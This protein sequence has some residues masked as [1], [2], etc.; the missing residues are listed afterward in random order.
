MFR[1]TPSDSISLPLRLGHA[2]TPG[3]LD[4]QESSIRR[5]NELV[6][7]A[8]VRSGSRTKRGSD[9]PYFISGVL[10]FES[11]DLAPD[12]LSTQ[13]R[14]SGIKNKNSSAAET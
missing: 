1:P 14:L 7:H 8:V 9:C 2:V 3:L 13:R 6:E 10:D 12:F 11:F 4:A 5:S